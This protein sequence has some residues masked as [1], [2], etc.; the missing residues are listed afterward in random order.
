LLIDAWQDG[1]VD[2][3]TGDIYL[4]QGVHTIKVEFVEAMVAARI[5]VWT[6]RLGR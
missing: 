6:E 3:V 2:D 5:H 4:D 1:P